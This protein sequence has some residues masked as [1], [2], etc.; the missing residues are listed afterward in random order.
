MG[1]IKDIYKNVWLLSKVRK[2]I[3]GWEKSGFLAE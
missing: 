1:F 3:L 2:G